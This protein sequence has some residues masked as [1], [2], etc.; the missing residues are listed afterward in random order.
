MQRWMIEVFH[1][2]LKSGCRIEDRQLGTVRRLE[3]CL[4]IDMVV[5]V[6]IMH[7]TWL[8]RTMP[9]LPCT[10]LLR[11]QS[12]EGALLLSHPQAHATEERCRQFSDVVGWIAKARRSPRPQ[13]R[14]SEPGTQVLWEGIQRADDIIAAMTI[15]A[16]FA[17]GP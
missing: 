7:L 16:N 3:N 5:A 11:R 17:H 1:R 4:A 12:V 13:V 6:R 2:T 8:G 15:H 9:K 14:P 10:D